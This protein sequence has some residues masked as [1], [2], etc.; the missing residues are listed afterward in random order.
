VCVCVCVCVCV[1]YLGR[2]Q[3]KGLLEY[4]R[5]ACIPVFTFFARVPPLPNCR[6]VGEYEPGRDT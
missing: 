3:R 5:A 4:V 2:R 6:A 1:L